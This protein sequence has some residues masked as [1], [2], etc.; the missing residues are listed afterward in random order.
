M[1]HLIESLM[2]DSDSIIDLESMSMAVKEMRTSLISGKQIIFIDQF[3]EW[4]IIENTIREIRTSLTL[5][6]EIATLIR[7][8]NNQVVFNVGFRDGKNSLSEI[9]DWIIAKNHEFHIA[10]YKVGQ[11]SLENILT[12]GIET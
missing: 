3:I 9:V 12:H 2:I 8:L 5:Q 10:E 11:P 4:A 6:F 1:E 7:R